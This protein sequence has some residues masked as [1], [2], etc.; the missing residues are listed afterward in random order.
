MLGKK[1]CVFIAKTVGFQKI[2]HSFSNRCHLILL[3][4]QSRPESHTLQAE[5]FHPQVNGQEDKKISPGIIYKK[6]VQY[7]SDSHCTGTE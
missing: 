2:R 6:K 5:L 1:G 7:L 4:I 3:N